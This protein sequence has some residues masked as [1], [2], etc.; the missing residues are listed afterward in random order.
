MVNSR[1]ISVITPFITGGY[2]VALDTFGDEWAWIR[3]NKDFHARLFISVFSFSLLMLFLKGLIKPER[4]E[5]DSMAREILFAFIETVGAIVQT[6]IIRFR[7][8]IPEIR[9]NSN[10]FEKITHPLDQIRA[11]ANGTALFLQKE[12]GLKENELEITVL[13][14]RG[15]G[16][17]H[18]YFQ[19]QQWKHS[20]PNELMSRRAAAKKCIETGEP[21][22]FPDKFAAARD[23]KFIL[24]ERDKRRLTGS[25]FVYPS[26]FEFPA[27]KVETIVS[28]V[29][30]G[31]QLC[32][33]HETQTVLLTQAILREFSRRFEIELCLDSIKTAN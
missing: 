17:W 10:K 14:R 19:L 7:E 25:A 29:T 6:K 23:G 21:L 1:L 33:T 12:Y 4:L 13:R 27:E 30:Y 32:E 16:D 2:F 9:P 11:I 15:A 20:A 31:R 3:D 18:F 5:S 24:S 8:K 28:I 26:T 22:F